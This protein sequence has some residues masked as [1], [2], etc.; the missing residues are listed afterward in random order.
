[1]STKSLQTFDHAAPTL[2]ANVYIADSARIIGD[3]SLGDNCSVWP[4]ATIRGDVNSIR[5]GARTSIQD[6]AVLHCTHK[7]VA[8]PDGYPLVIG[9]GVTVGH[10]AVLHGCT[11][12]DNVLIGIHATVLDGALVPDNV[13][14]GAGCLV[15]PKAQLESGYL[16]I[17]SPAKKARAISAEEIAYL[18]YSA[19][20]YVKL[21]DQYL[22]QENAG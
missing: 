11:I 15:P 9:S 2:G 14:I 19:N 16:Y 8:N 20:N 6:N 4:M 10:S 3:T 5:I 22:S 13:M 18:D 12:G 21:K 17:G 1:M 7:S